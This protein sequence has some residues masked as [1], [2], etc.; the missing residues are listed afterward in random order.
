MSFAKKDQN[1]GRGDKIAEARRRSEKHGDDFAALGD[2][3]TNLET[4]R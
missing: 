4:R 1:A 3:S 2:H